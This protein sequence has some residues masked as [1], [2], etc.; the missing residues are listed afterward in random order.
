MEKIKGILAQIYMEMRKNRTVKNAILSEINYNISK[1]PGIGEN[2]FTYSED[3]YKK[4]LNNI[5]CF[6]KDSE[7]I[8]LHYRLIARYTAHQEKIYNSS[9]EKIDFKNHD[10][11]TAHLEKEIKK[12]GSE[13]VMKKKKRIKKNVLFLISTVIIGAFLLWINNDLKINNRFFYANGTKVKAFL[14]ATWKMSPKEIERANNTYLYD[15]SDYSHDYFFESTDNK[16]NIL[17]PIRYE[18]YF[19]KELSLY[20]HETTIKYLFFDKKLF[21]YHVLIKNILTDSIPYFIRSNLA[22][23]YGNNSN[24][25]SMDKLSNILY[26]KEIT[27]ENEQL[28]IQYYESIPHFTNKT[29]EVGI[30]YSYK[31]MLLEI[32]QISSKE[33]QSIF[34]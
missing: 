5:S 26:V 19:E 12:T 3:L 31:P 11:I 23:K 13:I 4:N 29:Y 25:F 32:E 15:C 28:I 22:D 14:N 33:Y 2:P 10:N 8:I 16:P 34:D 30:I 20:N 24:E 6:K 7:K 1:K 18:A 9:S 17:N 27:W 21:E